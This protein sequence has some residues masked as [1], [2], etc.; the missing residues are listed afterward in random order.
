MFPMKNWCKEVTFPS[1]RNDF[2]KYQNASWRLEGWK[3]SLFLILRGYKSKTQTFFYIFQQ[4]GSVVN[5]QCWSY[6]SSC[7]YNYSGGLQ[8]QTVKSH[9]M[10]SQL[11]ST[12]FYGPR[13]FGQSCRAWKYLYFEYWHVHVA[14]RRPELWQ[15]SRFPHFQ[16]GD[17]TKFE[18]QLKMAFFCQFFLFFQSRS[19]Y[20]MY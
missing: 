17:L 1:T 2:S 18:N 12:V 14:Q 8:S 5:S 10:K 19:Y 9:F 4:F 6:L 11:P 3:F 15:T 20:N 7:S 16:R 13:A